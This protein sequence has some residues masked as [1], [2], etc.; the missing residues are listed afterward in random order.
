MTKV[1]SNIGN[2][3]ELFHIGLFVNAV[4]KCLSLLAWWHLANV[5]IHSAIS[6]KHKLLNKLVCLFRHMQMHSRGNSVL[7]NVE[8]LLF[9]IKFHSSFLE[10]LMT[11]FLS[12]FMECENLLRQVAL[13]RLNDFLSLLVAEATI[14]VNHRVTNLILVNLSIIIHFK[15]YRVAKFVFMWTERANVVTQP[16]REHWHSAVNEVDR[17]S[18]SIGLLVNHAIGF[19]I[20][21]YISNVHWQVSRLTM[22]HHSPLHRRGR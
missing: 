13:T 15:H 14:T 4:D 5:G 20:V 16:L 22:R 2:V 9:T 17:S 8:V 7:V 11:Q 12:K 18:T 3:V 1:G 21:G 19:Y 6:K 10:A